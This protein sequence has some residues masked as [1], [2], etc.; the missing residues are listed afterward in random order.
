[1]SAVNTDDNQS[2]VRLDDESGTVR[3][4]NDDSTVRLDSDT[5]AGGGA[6]INPIMGNIA[7][8]IPQ[9]NAKINSSASVKTGEVF[10]KGQDV[11]INGK[12]YAVED[13]ISMSSG[14]A[15]IY[16]VNADGKPAVLK[17]Y[18]PGS[19]YPEAVLSVIK[20]NPKSRIVKLFE[21]G[22]RNDQDYEIM[23]YAE[24]GTLDQYLKDNGPVRD[25]EKL[26]NIVGQITEGLEQLHNELNIVYQDLK[27]EN[28]YFKDASKTSIILADFG[29]SS[30]MKP[31]EKMIEAPANATTVYAAPDLARIG[32]NKNVK[33]GQSVDYFAL[34]ITML[35]LWLGEKPFSDMPESERVRQI[36]DKAVEFPQDMDANYKSL[37]QGLIQPLPNDR[38]GNQQIKKWLAGES[39]KSNYQKTIINYEQQMFNENESFSSPAELAALLAKYP[40]RG[41]IALYSDIVRSWLERSGNNILYEEIKNIISAYAD[42]KDAGLYSAIYKLDPMKPFVSNGGKTCSGIAEIAEVIMVES[43]FYME[44]LKKPNARLYLY[45]EA[46]EGSNG[47]VIT[48]QFRKNFEEY[49]PRRALKLMYLKLQP[50]GGKSIKIGFKTYQE[51]E[52]IA[53]EKD[54]TQ[55]MLI[56][57]AV[58]DEDSLLLVW[59]SDRYGEYFTTTDGFLNNKT[60]TQDRFFLLKLFPFLSFKEIVKDWEQVAVSELITLIHFSPG[61]SDLFDEYVKQDLPFKGRSKVIDW[62]PTALG[63]LTR[64]FKDIADSETCFELVR[65]LHKHG[66]DINEENGDGSVPLINAVFARN[67]PLVKLL[68]ELGADPNKA[69]NN[70]TPL[71]LAVC[72]QSD[73]DE[74][75]KRI[76]IAN[77]LLDYNADVKK[78]DNEDRAVLGISIF[79][80]SSE[81]VD[82]ITK[83]IKAGADI[84]RVDLKGNTPLFFASFAASILKNKQSALAVMEILLNKGAKTEIL[85]KSG[86]FSPLMIAAE[87]DGIE[88]VQLLLKH[89]AKKDFADKDENIAFVYAARKNNTQIMKLL[90]PGTAFKFKSGLF[91]F[92]KVVITILTAGVVFFT[93][94]VLARIVLTLHFSYPVLLGASVL[95]SHLFAAYILIV[96]LGLN[97]YMIRLRGTF[98]FIGR[99]IQYILGI[100]VVFPLV[101]LLLQFL[102]RFLPPKVSEILSYPA[103]MITRRDTTM[104]AWYFALLAAL[105][106]ISIFSSKINDKFAKKRQIYK[107]Y[108]Y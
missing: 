47:K 80:E 73:N 30:V 56:K 59:L 107:R 91:S 40:D 2:T 63:Y 105:L 95:F 43:A 23:E 67:V 90:E 45:F 29:I 46:V 32:N 85:L 55:I 54:V 13:C 57:V 21:Y 4:D 92:L 89:G 81:K 101:V 27:P 10:T 36:R 31:G 108:S 88:A 39:L 9:Q 58:C 8:I 72:S 78:I 53:A 11:E 66:A 97:E 94:D 44:E 50:D 16:K 83:L 18:N 1:M 70:I 5:A 75:E 69:Y 61:R 35:Q 77:L 99:S 51:P 86:D 68:L 103:E 17:Y 65:F 76:A 37:I 49:S 104:A 62:Q 3:L 26:K 52:E 82:F 28:I 22:R 60:K 6:A 79:F 14:E 96:F 38:W 20:N 48:E 33:I 19:P 93:M 15:V 12:K 24:G 25:I 106:V 84:N 87:Q 34:G 42:D 74:E 98:N 64:F 71:F 7:G 100:P 102:T 41:I